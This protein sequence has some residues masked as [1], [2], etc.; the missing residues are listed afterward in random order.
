MGIWIYRDHLV[1]LDSLWNSPKT[2][3]CPYCTTTLSVVG[4]VPFYEPAGA[5]VSAE[6]GSTA[7]RCCEV[8]GWWDVSATSYATEV[9]AIGG[10]DATHTRYVQGTLRN[11]DLLDIHQALEDVRRYLVGKQ[12]KLGLLALRLVE[13]LVG[14]I[15]KNSGFTVELT[16]QTRDGGID[17]YLL[18]GL[19]DRLVGVE[20]KRWKK[21]V[22]V[23]QIRSFLGALQ[24]AGVTQGVFVGTSGFSAGA[25]TASQEAKRIL[26]TPIRLVDSDWL[27]Q[28]MKV[29]QRPTVY[30][31]EDNDAPFSDVLRNINALEAHSSYEESYDPNDMSTW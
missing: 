14:D 21:R 29:A 7:V 16:P 19:G 2:T 20:V 30:S 26:G 8:C 15:F 3:P 27:L 28:E 6:R 31:L 1:G 9:T 23:G 17:L 12:E 25:H 13:E 24:L 10:M 22:Y 11:L 18:S 5:G 4:E